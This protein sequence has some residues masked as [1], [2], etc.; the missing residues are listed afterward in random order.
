MRF[1]TT[2]PRGD[3]TGFG[4][5]SPTFSTPFPDEAGVAAI[6]YYITLDDDDDDDVEPIEIPDASW[7]AAFAAA[8]PIIF[9]CALVLLIGMAALFVASKRQ[10]APQPVPAPTPSVI[11]AAA[12]PSAAPA[13]TVTI[14]P[15]PPATVTAT[16]TL[17]AA[18]PA[19]PPT[20]PRL[21]ESS[22]VSA[23]NPD[24]VFR[25][26]VLGI[27]GIT[28]EDWGITEAGVHRVCGY[29]R[30][31]HSHDDAA[32]QV[33]ANDPTF[34]PWQASAMANAS[35]TAYCPG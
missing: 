27:P 29:L 18:P 33:F 32:Q 31:G 12:L 8:S 28:V 20:S 34:T 26:L 13:P 21:P 5:A 9:A 25:Q 7:R 17:Q 14:T 24:A 11:P 4:S 23:P 30:A 19:P 3:G 10:D 16:A 1:G 6:D 15:T 2:R 22:K 35:A